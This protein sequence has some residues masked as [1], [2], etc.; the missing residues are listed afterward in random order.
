MNQEE[1]KG[2][3]IQLDQSEFD[4]ILGMDWLMKHGA[5]IDCQ[6]QRVSLKGKDGGKVYIWGT[7]S[8]KEI[9]I[10]SLMAI[11]KLIRKG[12]DAYL[13]YVTEDKKDGI[14]LEDIPIVRE[15]PDVF[16]EEIPGLPPSREI[17][18]EIE[19]EPGARPISKPPYR[20]A[21]M[22]LKDVGK[23]NNGCRKT[24]NY[25]LCRGRNH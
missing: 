16:P 8:T 10:I 2:E 24:E 1:F 6:R 19:L 13:C 5:K 18:F 20:M 3:L 22:E 21:P 12:H 11:G 15:F 4:I 23:Q 9:P 25:K 14:K 17:E 7:H